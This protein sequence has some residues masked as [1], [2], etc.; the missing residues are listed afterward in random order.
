MINSSRWVHHVQVYV[1]GVRGLSVLVE[2][3]RELWR[4]SE[5]RVAKPCN[6]L[7]KA[8]WLSDALS[9]VIH[10]RSVK[11]PF[12]LKFSPQRPPKST[13]Q[14]RVKGL[15][16]ELGIE[17]LPVHIWNCDE[18]GLQDHFVSARVVAEVG[19]LCFEIT[20]NEREETTTLLACLN[21]AGKCGP[22]LVIFK[23]FG[24]NSV[25]GHQSIPLSEYQ[26]MDRSTLRCFWIGESTS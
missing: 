8:F 25:L 23:G 2:L 20:A 4:S 24:L 15:I 16:T 5:C 19:S 26:T 22:L 13:L 18:T 7:W 9:V 11:F 3:A 17:D 21:A 14:R 12:F 10:S 1:L 6:D